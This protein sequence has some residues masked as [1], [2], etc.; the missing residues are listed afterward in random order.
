MLEA[1]QVHQPADDDEDRDRDVVL[2]HGA[3]GP[4]DSLALGRRARAGALAVVDCVFSGG[5]IEARV[6]V[7]REG[8]R[9]HAGSS[10]V[11]DC[12]A[13]RVAD[14]RICVSDALVVLVARR[15]L[16]AY[17]SGP[18]PRWASAHLTQAVKYSEHIGGG[19]DIVDD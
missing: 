18:R 13:H 19:V 6:G 12:L 14:G 1:V 8:N 2:D 3:A 10:C 9:V 16:T 4:V 7:H 15:V 17:V 11:L 5:S